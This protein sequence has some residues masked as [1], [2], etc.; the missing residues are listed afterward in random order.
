MELMELDSLQSSIQQQYG[1]IK[2]KLHKDVILPL[3]SGISCGGFFIY[4]TPIIYTQELDQ[5]KSF[6]RDSTVNA[7]KIGG[8][9]MQS[10]VIIQ[11][12]NKQADQNYQSQ[13][14]SIQMQ[15]I[16]N[17]S[18]MSFSY[19]HNNISPDFIQDSL[20]KF[21]PVLKNINTKNMIPIIDFEEYNEK[22]EE[23]K[24]SVELKYLLLSLYEILPRLSENSASTLLMR[25]PVF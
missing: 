7:S 11:Q 3:L 6:F 22:N 5:N 1:Q 21:M 16:Q 25:Y 10:S 19:L 17:Q 4:G 15:A 2:E 23:F 20:F 12:Q 8:V 24:S 18:N 13:Y 14:N 9:G